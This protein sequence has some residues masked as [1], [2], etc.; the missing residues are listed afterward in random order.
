M[1]VPLKWLKEYVD[2]DQNVIEFGDRMTMSGSKVEGIESFGEGINGVVVGKIESI[3]PH[4]NADKLV[5]TQI[6]IGDQT[7]QI[8]T[9]AKNINEGDYIPVATVGSNLAGGLKI[10]K[11]KLRG[12][13]SEGMLCSQEELG[14]P[15]KLIPE[16]L[17]DGI[18]ILDK[19][20]KLGANIFDVAEL[21][22]D[23]IEFEIT[24]NRPD[25]LSM[26]GMAREAVA[27]IGGRVKHPEVAIKAE[28]ETTTF[29]VKVDIHDQEGCTR[30]IARVIKDAVIQ[31][32]PL[33]MQQRLMKA[34]VRPINNIVD[35]TNYVMLEYGQPLHAFDMDY[36]ADNSII[37]RKA[38]DGEI[39]KTL[40]DVE[41]QL[42][43]TMTV[44]ADTTKALA[45]AGVMGGEESEVTENTKTI[46]LESAHF[47]KDR[48]RAT[49]KQIGLRTEAS[50]RYEKGVDSNIASIA[51]DRACQLI[52]MLGAGT[53]LKESVDVYPAAKEAR[54]LKIR[55][56]RMND[57]LGIK[58]TVEEMINILKSLEISAEEDGEH[59][60]VTVPTFRDDLQM[61]ADFLE[62][63]G[64]IYGFDKIPSTMA[65]GN[66]VV[67]G[68]T[69]GQLIED[70]AKESLLSLGFNE[71]LT[72]SFV[73]PKSV[74]KIN[75]GENSIKRNFVKLLNPLGDETSVMRTSLLPNMM[76]VLSRNV[77]HKVEAA[78]AF[79]LGSIFIPKSECNAKDPLPY[80]IA[81]LV[82]GMYGNE[83]FY[84]LK[85]VVEA[86][87]N[88]L[89]IKDL[90]FE[91]EK[92]HTSFHPGRCANIF[93]GGHIVGVMGELHPQVAENYDISKRCYI[94]E[95]DFYL[96]MQFTRVTTM[97]KPLPKYPAMTRDLA[98]IVKEEIMVR[99]IEKIIQANGGDILE[100]FELFD[101]YR[102]NQIPE[103]HKSI[104]YTITY[105]HSDR[106]LT[107][108]EVN[109]V[110]D[111]VVAGIKSEIGGTLRE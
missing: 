107:D 79:E 89:G 52:E 93:V 24:S 25:C 109:K 71:I 58:L 74:D 4:P 41:R 77:N 23:I 70:R 94:A 92:N 19:P 97:Y 45:I 80:E 69:N 84:S 21:Q 31:P 59:L 42:D 60:V 105:R 27:T 111:A 9:G 73:S 108:E 50:A 78:R 38:N 47:N 15:M 87:F 1:L 66:I 6:N 96:M 17:K 26:I 57:L 18:W 88:R 43:E 28:D 51:A 95:L 76:E 81:N 39:F 12:E 16:E 44:I 72:F 110:Q 53:V 63:L 20:Y 36:I 30:Y 2:I 35:I 55:H 101:L 11:G 103:G 86:L 14:I 46:L 29:G 106:T 5:I 33:W 61:E 67:G 22:D 56:G 7:L 48:I 82:I 32:S 100:S 75:V 85:G 54:Q 62:E 10:K 91:V 99:E 102:G 104:A 90:E 64:R 13:V 40:D 98:V 65:K 83:D 37:V 68:K 8:V 49:S 3:Q 34:G